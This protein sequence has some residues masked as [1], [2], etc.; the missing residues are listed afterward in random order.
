MKTEQTQLI[1]DYKGKVESLTIQKDH[2]TKLRENF[3]T[4]RDK[5]SDL[6]EHVA[7]LEAKIQIAQEEIAQIEA[8]FSTVRQ[9]YEK[10]NAI[11]ICL[12]INI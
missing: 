12:F 4:A 11:N 6:T 10:R 7:S 5:A 2:A 3:E 8:V 1:R 9:I